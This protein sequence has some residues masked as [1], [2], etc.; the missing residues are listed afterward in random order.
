MVENTQI[1]DKMVYIIVME[2]NMNQ[3][4]NQEKKVINIIDSEGKS[5]EVEVIFSFGFT[6]LNKK[7]IVYTKNEQDANENTTI[8][9]SEI[10]E[11][12]EGIPNLIGISSDE[13]WTRIKNL[14]RDI[15]KL[16]TENL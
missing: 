2:G 13:E 11:Q 14:L 7:Y 15:S 6:D 16:D 9:I 8:Y 3:N 12:P 4:I 1:Y 5:E 10:Q